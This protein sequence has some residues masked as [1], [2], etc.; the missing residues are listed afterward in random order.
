MSLPVIISG[1]IKAYCS[2]LIVNEDQKIYFLSV[3][4]Y[5]AAVK[6]IIANVLEYGSVTVI[7][8]DEY[9]YPS[10]S[11]LNYTVHYQKLP[12]ELFQ[13]VTLL[14][15]AL[16]DNKEPKDCFLVISEDSPSVKDLFFRHL[17]NKIEIPLHPV[18]SQWLWNTFSEKGWPTPLDTLIGDFKGY[19]VEI[20]EEE[21]K[22]IISMAITERNPEVIRCF[23]KGEK[24]GRDKLFEGFP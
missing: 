10:R 19:L 8:D 2:E 16:P 5:Q 7:V 11:T 6:G 3:A 12:S 1:G 23:E 15:I 20:N 14:K 22:D 4:G 9:F 17:E 24:D 13:G 18:W 21:L